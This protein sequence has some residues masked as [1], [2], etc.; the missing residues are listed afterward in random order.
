MDKNRLILELLPQAWRRDLGPEGLRSAEEIRLRLGRAPC[1]LAEGR[2]R[3]FR[4]EP[5]TEEELL[6]ILE[7]ATGAS[8]YAASR[9][10]AE[11]Y[12]N[13]R[14][15]RIGVCGTGTVQNGQIGSYGQI[16]SLAVRIPGEFP[17]ICSAEAERLLREGFQNTLLIGP[18]GAG[19]TTALRELIRRFSEGGYRVGVADERNEL[20]AKD[21]AEIC[22]DLGCRTDVLTGIPKA[23]AAMMLLRGLNPQIIAMDEITREDDAKALDQIT[24]CGVGILAS[25]H[26]EDRDSL[27]RRSACRKLLEEHVFQWFLQIQQR[28]KDRRYRLERCYP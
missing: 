19:K 1:V 6:R 23:E 16:S 27:M 21:G 3:A 5:V 2:E 8:F 17:G 13:Y 7:K 24:G 4:V 18:P 28:G 20:A 25:V 15:I 14:G 10:M 9:A 22:C 12:L 11:G 26:G